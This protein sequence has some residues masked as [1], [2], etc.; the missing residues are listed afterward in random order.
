MHALYLFIFKINSYFSAGIKIWNFQLLCSRIFISFYNN[1]NHYH[2]YNDICAIIV[3]IIVAVPNTAFISIYNIVTIATA[4]LL[5][6]LSFMIITII[7]ILF[8]CRK[9]QS[10]RTVLVSQLR[11]NYI[12]TKHKQDYKSYY[13]S[14]TY[15]TQELKAPDVRDLPA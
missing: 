4:F 1:D 5:S 8:A 7:V 9:R 11:Q 6:L 14:N 13:K 10:N 12:P 15:I 2:K 3:I